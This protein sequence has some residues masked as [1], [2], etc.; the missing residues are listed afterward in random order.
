MESWGEKPPK[1]GER[2]VLIATSH[3]KPISLVPAMP[4][5]SWMNGLA[6]TDHWLPTSVANQTG[7]MILNDQEVELTWNGG[8]S[9]SDL[10]ILAREA[11]TDTRFISYLGNGIVTWQLPFSFYLPSEVNLRLRGPSNWGKEGAFPIEQILDADSRLVGVSMNWKLTRIGTPVR[12]EV[13]EPICMIY[14]E[15]RGLAEHVNP[16]VRISDGGVPL[17]ERAIPVNNEI[18]PRSRTGQWRSS[19][20]AGENVTAK[21][22]TNRSESM[23]KRQFAQQVGASQELDG[24]LS[25]GIPVSPVANP[26]YNSKS[27]LEPFYLQGD[28]YD[29]ATVLRDQFERALSSASSTDPNANPFTYAYSENSY[30]FLA[31]CAEKLFGPDVVF[32]FLDKLRAWARQTL[33][34][35]YASTP[36][37]QIFIRGNQRH[38]AKDDIR[39]A[40]HYVL[41]ITRSEKEIRRAKFIL[42]SPSARPRG[43]RWGLTSVQRVMLNFNELLV[44]NVK[45][46]YGVDEVKATTDLSKGLVLLE[47]YLW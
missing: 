41:S 17:Q 20:S 3:A 40:W 27:H 28:F 37:V 44:H 23:A 22:N 12:F 35:A 9:P 8:R 39:V 47:G 34:V 13:G 38:F 21:A 4:D 14:P 31:A 7:W 45:L 29:Q 6:A 43:V 2:V 25:A 11:T 32:R 1:A 36:R 16:E 46:A 5:R 26:A 19:K 10:S 15:L 42:E 18:S 30:Q 24:P 33:G